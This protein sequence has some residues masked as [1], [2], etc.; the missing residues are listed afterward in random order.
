[1]EEIFLVKNR[2]AFITG[3]S[4]G[5]GKHFA[6]TLS[7]YGADLILVGR[8]PERLA[9]VEQKCKAQG[10]K[11]AVIHQDLNETDAM[12]ALIQQAKKNFSHV[13]ILINSAGV[14]LRVP[15]LE[16]T[17]AQWDKVIDTNLKRTFFLTQ[18]IAQ[19]MIE[20][21]TAGSIINVSSS[22]AFHTTSTRSIYSASK[23]GVESLTRSLALSL[24]QHKIRVNCI[25]PGF[26]VTDL[27]RDYLQTEIGKHEI[28]H[29]PMQRAA[30]VTELE[31]VL[32]LLASNAS[33]FMT[34]SV[35]RVDGGF[36]IS[37][38]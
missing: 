6:I 27:T 32:L 16:N 18:A 14:G 22:A 33:S 11:T 4:S 21:Q 3:A 36:S 31:G 25:A 24:I 34:G 37:K 26:F 13:D 7:K 30:N 19:W 20:T 1:M 5:I 29:L 10:S 23:I 12:P 28:A 35:V 38:I 9:E 8:H 17:E 2:V 15:F